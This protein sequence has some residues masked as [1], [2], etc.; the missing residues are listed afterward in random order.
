MDDNV[1]LAC[2]ITAS[3]PALHLAPPSAPPPPP[4]LPPPPPPPP[5]PAPPVPHGG[6]A[7]AAVSAQAKESGVAAHAEDSGQHQYTHLLARLLHGY[8]I[9]ALQSL[10]ADTPW[11]AVVVGG[12]ALNVYLDAAYRLTSMD[13]DLNVWDSSSGTADGG[14]TEEAQRTVG[15]WM[16]AALEQAVVRERFRID[17]LDAY[18]GVRLERVVYESNPNPFVLYTGETVTVG[19]V[20][21]VVA[22]LAR[23]WALIDVVGRAWA[24]DDYV[25]FDGVNFLS[26]PLLVDDMRA[27]IA[28]KGYKKR[29]RT[30]AKLAAFFDAVAAG[31]LSCNYYGLVL[32][33]LPVV[34]PSAACANNVQ[35]DADTLERE[36]ANALQRMVGCVR[37]TVLGPDTE[38]VLLSRLLGR[39]VAPRRPR[40]LVAPQDV[41]AH[42]AYIRALDPEARRTLAAYTY[43]WSAALNTGLLRHFALDP[44]GP[45]SAAALVLQR[46]LL[47]APPLTH[48][49]VVYRVA[50]FVFFAGRSQC[51]LAVGH[52]QTQF[53][54]TSTT[55]D[56]HAN[57]GPFMDEFAPCCAYVIRV[58]AGSRGVLI[59]GAESALPGEAEMLLPALCAL[60]IRGQIAANVTY[61]SRFPSFAA[62][63]AER[64]WYV[65]PPPPPTTPRAAPLPST[66]PVGIAPAGP[67]K[68]AGGCALRAVA[69]ER[70]GS[71]LFNNMRVYV[72]DY[73]PP[74]LALQASLSLRATPAEMDLLLAPLRSLPMPRQPS[75][76]VLHLGG[77]DVD[78]D[79]DDNDDD[80]GGGDDDDDGDGDDDDDDDG[81]DDDDDDDAA[82]KCNAPPLVPLRDYVDLSALA[83]SHAHADAALADPAAREF[84]AAVYAMEIGAW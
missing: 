73:V 11:R 1:L 51:D 71:T 27:L 52:R 23:P 35:G 36:V 30:E 79:D 59:I 78:V 61:R 65:S 10:G 5:P 7:G 50:R 32:R 21:M 29:A 72:A 44:S 18:Y 41:A 12:A 60:D 45:P 81:D 56:N 80:D 13:W 77:D 64:P 9:Q 68:P 22:G 70:A 40:F 48:D 17:V 28:L 74:P 20:N 66:G 55:M 8:V 34:L 25:T 6:P 15:E 19:H 53:T 76:L 83:K 47:G 63:D 26:P 46:A 42:R 58:P 33:A 75:F 38:R 62:L 3:P 69:R 24:S 49:A 31:G 54:F 84:L 57:L 67:R 2:A 82:G 4:P 39:A 43:T 37:G 14:G 16:A